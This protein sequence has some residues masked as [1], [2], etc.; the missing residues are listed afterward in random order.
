MRSDLRREEL[1]EIFDDQVEGI[2]ALIDE[3]INNLAR[4][5]PGEQIVSDAMRRMQQATKTKGSV[6]FLVL[7]DNVWRPRIF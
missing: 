5:H 7:L 3:Q 6:Y 2:I 4:K 1:K